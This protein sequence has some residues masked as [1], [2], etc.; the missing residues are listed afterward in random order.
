MVVSFLSRTRHKLRSGGI[1]LCAGLALGFLA[2][3]PVRSE[4]VTIVALGDS[5]TQGY[6]LAPQDGFVAQMERALRA[7]GEQVAIVNA[8]VSGDTSAGGLSRIDWTLTPDIDAVVVALGGNDVL[9]GLPPARTRDNLAAILDRIALRGLPVLLVGI[10]APS[11]FGPGFQAE[12]DAIFPELAD[13]DGVALF[14][15]FLSAIAALPDREAA[16]RDFMQDDGIHPNARGV[17]LIVKAMAPALTR[18]A[19]RARQ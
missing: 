12:F 14:P 18:L 9:R 4:P 8:G 16:R 7:A 17:A 6:G 2:V 10:R 15:D 5:L 11:N 3:S 19:D 13:R 1:K